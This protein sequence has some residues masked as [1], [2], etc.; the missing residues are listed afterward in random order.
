[1][2]RVLHCIHSISGGGAERQLRLLANV[3]VGYGMYAAIFCVSDEGSN[4]IDQSVKIYKSK[5]AH[6]YDIEIFPALHAAIGDFAPHIVHVWVPVAVT[7]PSL[8]VSAWHRIPC[9]FS[10][11]NPM[12]FERLA[13]YGEFI[14]ATAF[15]KKVV[16]NNLIEQSS[17]AFRWLY[18]QKNGETIFNAVS[19]DRQVNGYKA[20]R[21]YFRFLFVGR[22]TR[23]KNV[24]FMLDAL[25]GLLHKSNWILDIF[26]VGELEGQV[27]EAIKNW[28]LSS[29]VNLRGYSNDIYHEM[30]D[31]DLLLFPSLYEGMSNVLLEALALGLPV[32]ASDIASS[33]Y[34]IRKI[35]CVYWFDCRSKQQFAAGIEQFIHN[36]GLFA[37]KVEN[38]KEL[39]EKFSKEVMATSY[40]NLY[41]ALI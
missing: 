26:G 31:A 32:I 38:G 37:K 24:L 9:V 10:Y 30:H 12:L 14:L 29:R 22:L 21:N 25:K 36:P 23:Q 34:I 5:R 15:C 19:A 33:R 2:I 41:Q 39:A 18:R 1:M 20:T 27:R 3:S 16:S 13:T 35:D 7:I 6:R 11:R 8:L 40:S 28:G 4:G 17:P